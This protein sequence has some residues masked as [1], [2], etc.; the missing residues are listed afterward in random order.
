MLAL[1]ALA[2]PWTTGCDTEEEIRRE[3]QRLFLSATPELICP[4]VFNPEL[5]QILVQATVFSDDGQVST[6]TRVDIGTDSFAVP[7]EFTGETDD[8]GQ[9]TTSIEATRPPTEI[10]FFASIPDG[11]AATATVSTDVYPFMFLSASDSTLEVG[12]TVSITFNIANACGI[13]RFVADL[14]YSI[15][16]ETG[17]SVDVLDFV[18]GEF[19]E[20]EIFNSSSGGVET[21]E[22]IYAAQEV[23][24]SVRVEYGIASPTA[25]SYLTGSHL[26]IVFEAVNPGD[27]AIVFRSAVVTPSTL[28]GGTDFP[29]DLFSP[30]GGGDP[31]VTG[32]A[33][34]V[35]EPSAP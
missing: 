16:P 34:S 33:L 18:P 8:L 25:A 22:T 28:L 21:G 10:N 31:L 20:L 9:V 23:G 1:V 13:N 6:G 24:E 35:A 15:D 17:D 29:Y 5:N 3:N 30:P 32:I 26:A 11:D 12:D 7:F 19:R 2:A 27:V 4:D 14:D